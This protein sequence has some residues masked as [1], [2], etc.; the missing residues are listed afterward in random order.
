MT[1]YSY[2]RVDCFERCPYKYKLRYIDKLKTLPNYDAD[3]ALVL[4]T[5]LHKGLETD[6]ETA[7]KEYYSYFPIIT[8]E[9]I[10]EAIKLE[11]LIPKAKALLP[12]GGKSEVKID[13]ENFV[14]YIDYLCEDSDNNSLSIYDYKY[15]GN[16]NTYS[17][18]K[19]L[20]IYKYYQNNVEK[21]YYV[22][23]PKIKIRQKKTETLT[24]FRQ[25]LRQ[26]CEN[27]EV[28]VKEVT[29]DP[30]KVNEFHELINQIES[31]TEFPKNETRLCDWCEY[32][33][34]CRRGVDY[35]IV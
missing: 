7:I 3:N 5:A 23:I 35:D 15:T 25:R 28:A 17:Y 13:C 34:F 32:K 18:S 4:G 8:D 2:S 29:Y 27:A 31:A 10:N 21:L 24:E 33:E 26:T 6:V 1:Q 19:Q 9:Q 20:H 16:A 12:L 14:G 30:N 22:F 11:I